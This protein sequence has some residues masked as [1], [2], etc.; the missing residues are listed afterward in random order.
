MD[1]QPAAIPATATR[2]LNVAER[3]VQTRGFN[4]FSYA[5]IADE[6]G[7]T[8]A[9]L[10]YHFATKAQLGRTLIERYTGA[11]ETALHQITSAQADARGRLRAYVK[12]YADVLAEGR[13]CLCGMAAAEYGTLPETM[14]QALRE[15]FSSNERWLAQLLEQAQR[16]GYLSLRAPAA[17][18][19]SMLMSALEGAMLVARAMGDRD[20]FE[21]TARA[22][23]AQLQSAPA[24]RAGRAPR[25]M[26][27]RAGRRNPGRPRARPRG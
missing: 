21:A 13:M 14:Q 8:K 26:A 23:L 6:V 25:A 7:I 17:E 1:S 2:I 4:G 15:F 27:P 16:E 20:R 3:L 22:L 19:A 9:S 24:R 12:I 11:F 10:H 18:E 5:D